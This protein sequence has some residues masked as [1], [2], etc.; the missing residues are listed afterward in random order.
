MIPTEILRL[1]L[2]LPARHDNGIKS[3]SIPKSNDSQKA[4]SNFRYVQE[5]VADSLINASHL[6]F[7]IT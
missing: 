4:H 3:T 1:G 7:E 2:R 6:C 5:Q